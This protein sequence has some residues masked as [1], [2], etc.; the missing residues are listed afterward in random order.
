MQQKIVLFF[1]SALMRR[2]RDR[3][4]LYPGILEQPEN[5]ASV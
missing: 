5:N 4:A 1:C 3:G 2:N